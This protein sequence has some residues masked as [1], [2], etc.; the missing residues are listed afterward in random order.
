MYSIDLWTNTFRVNFEF[1]DAG[2]RRRIFST[3]ATAYSTSVYVHRPSYHLLCLWESESGHT[4]PHIGSS[5]HLTKVRLQ[6]RQLPSYDSP[7]ALGDR[8]FMLTIASTTLTY[9]GRLLCY[10]VLGN[11]FDP[12]ILTLTLT[13]SITP[14]LGKNIRIPHISILSVPCTM[15]KRYK[16]ACMI[17]SHN[18]CRSIIIHRDNVIKHDKTPETS[19]CVQVQ[20]RMQRRRQT[21]VSFRTTSMSFCDIRM[22]AEWKQPLAQTR[23]PPQR[24]RMHLL[25][26]PLWCNIS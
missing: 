22:P 4:M 13:L 12:L 19:T 10:A 7:T 11:A 2:L 1:M 9:T 6:Q 25:K 17:I 21:S 3:S 16:M 18:S 24:Y 5:W 20:R 15:W 26:P 14:T 8:Q 23:M